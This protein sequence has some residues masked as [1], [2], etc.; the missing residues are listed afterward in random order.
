MQKEVVK[1]MNKLKS[2]DL[3]SIINYYCYLEY[4]CPTHILNSYFS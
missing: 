2:F 1:V 3:R 4:Y